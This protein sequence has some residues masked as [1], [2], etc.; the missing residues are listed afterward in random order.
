MGST[1]AKFDT[2]DTYIGVKSMQSL[3]GEIFFVDLINPSTLGCS[4]ASC[5]GLMTWSDGTS[6]NFEPTFMT[7]DVSGD[8]INTCTTFNPDFKAKYADCNDLKHGLCQFPVGHCPSSKHAFKFFHYKA[9]STEFT[10]A[11]VTLTSISALPA[12]GA[13][14]YELVCASACTNTPLCDAFIVDKPMNVCRMGTLTTAF[15]SGL[16]GA[17]EE[18]LYSLIRI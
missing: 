18:V 14:S 10:N 7:H 5:N 13:H 17:G 8:A 16:T 2:E 15:L 3:T 9:D 11:A 12:S 6:F 4:G 1:L